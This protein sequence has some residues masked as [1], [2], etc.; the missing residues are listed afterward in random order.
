MRKLRNTTMKVRWACADKKAFILPV[1]R[2]E[3]IK[4]VWA[5]ARINKQQIVLI[6]SDI[7]YS[8]LDTE[9]ITT[10]LLY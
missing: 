3:Q 7:A 5:D 1:L 8:R 2:S 6:L 4:D 9:L 10:T